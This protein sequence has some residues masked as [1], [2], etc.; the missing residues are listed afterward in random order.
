MSTTMF[1]IPGGDYE[2]GGA[3]SS[4]LKDML[5][6]VGVEPAAL[7]RAMIAAYEAEMNVVIHSSHGGE[8]QVALDDGV[9]DVE[10]SDTGPGIP[11]VE[12]AMKEGFSTAPAKAREL[13]FGAGMG[14]PNIRR[15]SDR[16]SIESAAGQG[17]RLRFTIYLTP[18]AAVERAAGSLEVVAERCRECLRCL[19]VCP[20]RAL[21]VRGGR[22][23]V[24]EHLCI[25]CGACIGACE[26]GALAMKGVAEMPRQA[27]GTLLVVPPAFLVQFGPRVGP[28]AVLSALAELGFGEVWVTEGWEAAL[29][30]AVVRYA[31]EEAGAW[32]VISPACPAV[33]S[34]IEMRFPSLIGH[35]APFA[36]PVGAA[37]SEAAGRDALVVA[38]CPA[39]RSVLAALRGRTSEVVGPRG[40]WQAILRRVAE[41]GESASER[42]GEPGRA[43][44]VLRV[45]G[46]RHVVAALEEAENGRLGDVAV[47]ELFACDRGCFGS[48]AW[49][50]EPFVAAWRW[51][52]MG[53]RPLLAMGARLP[54][55]GALARA[56]QAVRRKEAFAPRAGLRLDEDM[57]RA[58][59][60]LAEMDRLIRELPGRDCGRCGA[61]TCSALAEDV[62]LGRA[63]VTACPFC[64]GAGSEEKRP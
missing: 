30:E 5:K 54:A 52:R 60:K 46:V 3:A 26:A 21:R 61:P 12:L 36:S 27:A 29:E 11:D 20:T 32:P 50:E 22:P 33:V 28:R 44:G 1:T 63:A 14:L 47:L 35:L 16:F 40:L 25:E 34:L 7:R 15:S 31:R 53:G 56:G 24:L 58:I 18:Q 48:P 41:G 57:A 64:G 38:A 45:T 42:A 59:A 23:E 39:Q 55:M 19:H 13:G 4:G 49:R 8:M 62:V 17:T 10:V 51:R 6:K 2:H 43:E 9:L 37:Q